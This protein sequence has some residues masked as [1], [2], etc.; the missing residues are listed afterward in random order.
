MKGIK[1]VPETIVTNTKRDLIVFIGTK[2]YWISKNCINGLLLALDMTNLISHVVPAEYFIYLL[3]LA[4]LVI[5]RLQQIL[6][7]SDM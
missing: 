2:F 3:I 1:I 6:M 7:R 4:I 5:Y